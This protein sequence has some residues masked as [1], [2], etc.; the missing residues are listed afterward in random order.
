MARTS[1]SQTTGSDLGTRCA[2]ALA[3]GSRPAPRRPDPHRRTAPR[4]SSAQLPWRGLPSRNSSARRASPSV[5]KYR[6]Q[7]T[8][9]RVAPA[10]PDASRGHRHRADPRPVH[11]HRRLGEIREREHRVLKPGQ[12]DERR[13]PT[14]RRSPSLER[15]LE[16]DVVIQ[17]PNPRSPPAVMVP[18]ARDDSTSRRAGV[19][20]SSARASRDQPSAAAAVR[21]AA[22]PPVQD[23]TT[24]RGLR[25]DDDHS[26]RTRSTP[27][28]ADSHLTHRPS[29]SQV[30][31]RLRWH[32]PDEPDAMRRGRD[33]ELRPPNEIS[34]CQRVA[35]SGRVDRRDGWGWIEA[36]REG[37]SSGAE[38]DHPVGVEAGYRRSLGLGG[39]RQVG[40]E[41]LETGDERLRPEQLDVVSGGQVDGDMAGVARRVDRRLRPS[42]QPSGSSQTRAARRRMRPKTGPIRWCREV[43]RLRDRRPSSGRRADLGSRRPR[44]RGPRP[45]V[46]R[47]PRRIAR[48]RRPPARWTYRS[49]ACRSTGSTRRERWPRRRRSRPGHRRRSGSPRACPNRARAVGRAERARRIRDPRSCRSTPWPHAS[50]PGALRFRSWLRLSPRRSPGR[51]GTGHRSS[52]SSQRSSL[53]ACRGRRT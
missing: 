23:A 6:P 17:A 41:R 48:A 22:H 18:P 38:L 34:G 33:R 47:S 19:A 1:L 53:T 25:S 7:R 3:D 5:T 40:P 4:P 14:R 8:H 13:A 49:P 43:T 12:T 46:R 45:P 9:A 27:T 36:L 42:A 35:G 11:R 31:T 39:E 16:I 28:R 37:R 24:H 2:R 21:A 32:R 20:A 26:S 10:G 52:R 50:R 29:C 51:C 30:V 44:L 15:A